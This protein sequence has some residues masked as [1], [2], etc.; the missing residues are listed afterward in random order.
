[1]L[2]LALIALAAAPDAGQSDADALRAWLKGR[3]KPTQASCVLKSAGTV[4][5]VEIG[6]ADAD[7]AD[8]AKAFM[9]E[10]AAAWNKGDLEAFAA[11]YS[12]D[13]TFI[14]P[15]GLT[16]GRDQVLARYKKRYPTRA[17]WAP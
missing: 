12:D 4:S 1:M 5:I 7:R 2:A 17:P 8:S 10:Q 13:A 3:S 15:A 14:T 9:T 11:S 6:S 16:R